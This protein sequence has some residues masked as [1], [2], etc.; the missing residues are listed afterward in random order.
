MKKNE[1]PRPEFLF[2]LPIKY[3][4]FMHHPHLS[5]PL[6]RLDRFPAKTL[7][8]FVSLHR[9]I[10]STPFS[11]KLSLFFSYFPCTH[12]HLKF[13]LNHRHQKIDDDAYHLVSNNSSLEKLPLWFMHHLMLFISR[14]VVDWSPF[15]FNLFLMDFGRI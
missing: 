7:A 10:T 12:S 4:M 1:V 11:P 8:N 3:V 2:D 13:S 9:S 14:F 5:P 6:S 15:Q